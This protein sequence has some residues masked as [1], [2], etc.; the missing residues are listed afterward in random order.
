[1]STQHAIQSERRP[2]GSMHPGEG[3][4][5]WAW[6]A[7]AV[8]LLASA[9]SVFLSVGM[10]LV[11]CPLCFY[12][13]TFA[14][15]VL[16]VLAVG[17]LAGGGRRGLLGLLALPAALGGLTVAGFHVYL[18]A[19][20]TL[21]CPLG[22]A[23]MGSAPQQ[24]LAMF[25]VLTLL[26]ALDVRAGWPEGGLGMSALLGAVVLGGLFGAGSILSAPPL[27]AAPTAPYRADQPLNG[28]RPP[29]HASR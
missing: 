13:R 22:V 5:L 9:G 18:E 26:L 3:A 28:C 17:L 15:G 11:A 25:V 12:Q 8:A 27:P 6:G 7:C 20:G 2:A 10:N 24:S 14:F 23:G 21:E 29:F 16:G 1:M 19:N 4:T